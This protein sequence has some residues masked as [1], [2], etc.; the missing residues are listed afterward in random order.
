MSEATMRQ[1]VGDHSVTEVLTIGREAIQAKAKKRLQELCDQYENGIQIVQLVLQDV[2]P[3]KPVRASFNEVNEANQERERMINEAEARYNRII[4]EA[5]GQAKQT[6][7]EAEG[8]ATERVN[9]AQGDVKR[10]LALQKE[11]NK[12]PDVTRTRLYLE[13]LSEV[14]PEAERR[15]VVDQNAE[16]LVSILPLDRMMS[17]SGGNASKGGAK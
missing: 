2:N 4:P 16:G 10:F 15:V 1:V 6:V 9:R 7:Q 14:L 5:K 17:Q 8:Y 11:Y 13:M 3:P 12:A